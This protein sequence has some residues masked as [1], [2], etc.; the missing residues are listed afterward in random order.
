MPRITALKQQLKRPDRFSIYV[1]GRFSFSLSDQQ[2]ADC[3]L[4]VGR[5]ITLADLAEYKQQSQTGKAL[6]A[7]YR[8]LSYRSRSCHEMKQRL[9]AKGYDEDTIEQVNQKLSRL[10][11]LDDE[12]FA[13]LWTQQL[14]SRTKSRS[15]LKSDLAQKRIS[16]DLIEQAMTDL[17]ED[18]DREAI[19]QLIQKQLNKKT[20]DRQ[21]LVGYLVRQGFRLGQVLQVIGQEF[22]EIR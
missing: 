4:T 11:L 16:P 20:P 14:K 7:A 12:N 8:L 3:D 17:D 10:R 9:A 6:V 19:K 2:L 21:K 22:T 15:R 18:H 13:Q 1:D 5:E